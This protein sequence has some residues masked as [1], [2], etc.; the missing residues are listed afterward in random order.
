MISA[1]FDFSAGG[2]DRKKL[3]SRLRPTPPHPIAHS[4]GYLRPICRHRREGHSEA[5]PQPKLRPRQSTLR[6]AAEILSDLAWSH[7]KKYNITRS[8]E[9][10]P[11]GNCTRLR[12]K[13]YK[14]AVLARRVSRQF[15]RC[16]RRDHSFEQG[17][18][19]Y[20]RAA[21]GS[22]PTSPGCP[23]E[24]RRTLHVSRGSPM[25]SPWAKCSNPNDC[26]GPQL[27]VSREAQRHHVQTSRMDKTVTVRLSGGQ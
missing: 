21:S 2:G 18:C 17:A 10:Q 14:F 24:C 20:R 1:A 8:G 25:F 7:P 19:R 23:H 12:R 13:K 3:P 5:A 27:I 4:S 15:V 22:D 9:P 6:F 16:G 26:V 11:I